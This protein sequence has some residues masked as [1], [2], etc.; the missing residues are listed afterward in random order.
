M[1]LKALDPMQVAIM[2]RLKSNG[3]NHPRSPLMEEQTKKTGSTQQDEILF[4]QRKEI[5]AFVGMW[6]EVEVIMLSKIIKK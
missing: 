6:M 3:R 1:Q 2:R 4:C 5:M